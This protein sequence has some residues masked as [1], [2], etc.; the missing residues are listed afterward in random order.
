MKLP[1]EDTENPGKDYHYREETGPRNR[2]GTGEGGRGLAP[3]DNPP[4][5][6]SFLAEPPL[7]ALSRGNRAGEELEESGM[8]NRY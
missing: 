3:L 2:L 1:E 8:W 6:A 7:G 4:D 5:K